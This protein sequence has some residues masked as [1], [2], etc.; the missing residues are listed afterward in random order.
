[1]WYHGHLL[2]LG[3]CSN[4]TIYL[5]FYSQIVNFISDIGG[6]LGLWAGF[7]VLSLLEIIELVILMFPKKQRTQVDDI[8]R[9]HKNE[10]EKKDNER[11]EVH[12]LV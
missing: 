11:V 2:F 10:M 3:K 12:D 7:S 4:K 6:Q 1:M 8:E 5:V 9:G